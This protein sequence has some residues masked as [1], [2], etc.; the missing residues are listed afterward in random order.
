MT[1]EEDSRIT[2]IAWV[3]EAL[4]SMYPGS[5]QSVDEKHEAVCHLLEAIVNWCEYTEVGFEL[6]LE[7]ALSECTKKEEKPRP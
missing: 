6:A 4:E 2:R 5:L 7:D 1:E 3:Q